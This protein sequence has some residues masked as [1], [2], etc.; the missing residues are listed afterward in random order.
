MRIIFTVCLSMFLV[1]FLCAQHDYDNEN[2][3]YSYENKVGIGTND[4]IYKFHVNGEDILLKRNNSNSLHFRVDANGDAFINNMDNF[5][6]NGS[7]GNENLFITGRKDLILQTGNAGTS[8]TERLRIAGL[9]G[10]VGINTSEPK[11]QLDVNGEISW[12]SEGAK[13]TANQ[14]CLYRIKRIRHTVYR[15]FK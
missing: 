11:T 10:Y 9:T 14:R 13:L 8:G 4:P 7:S 6:Q 1:N 12:G 2:I 15:F 3:I 5:L